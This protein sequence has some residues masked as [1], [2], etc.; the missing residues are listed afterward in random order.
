M[1]AP[2]HGGGIVFERSE[3]PFPRLWGPGSRPRSLTGSRLPLALH[4]RLMF[5]VCLLCGTVGFCYV[6]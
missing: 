1:V 2:H 4:R 5:F 3:A 6:V